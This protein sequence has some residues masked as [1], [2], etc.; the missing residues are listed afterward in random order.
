MEEAADIGLQKPADASDSNHVVIRVKKRNLIIAGVVALIIIIVVGGY[1]Y[2]NRNN[3]S[4]SQ[5][6]P[7]VSPAPTLVPTIS[8]ASIPPQVSPTGA[9][10]KKNPNSETGTVT[11]LGANSITI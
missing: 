1:L 6:Q 2:E 7:N 11:G 5:P 9:K 8:V 10:T 4:N 3:F